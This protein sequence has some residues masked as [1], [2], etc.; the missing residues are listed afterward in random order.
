MRVAGFIL[1][2]AC[3]APLAVAQ[4]MNIDF[5]WN[6]VG[7]VPNSTYSA[8]GIAGVWNNANVSTNNVSNLPLV[9]LAGFATSAVL[10]APSFGGNWSGSG[11]WSGN[12]QALM[13][14]LIGSG[15]NP[16]QI[17]FSGLTVGLY[18]VI[19]YGM[20]ATGNST[21]QFTINNITQTTGGA[22]AG[23]HTPGGS[24]TLFSNVVAV[25][26]MNISYLGNCNGIQLMH[27]PLPEPGSILALTGGFLAMGM[28]RLRRRSKLASTD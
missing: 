16:G 21:T 12:D 5:N 28:R 22:W 18:D 2:I 10:N 26:S 17:N 25:G 20:N 27:R 15:S 11:P 4:T 13:E 19:L 9:D 7:S 3:V 1:A 24:F 23:F 8:A 14:D 6:G